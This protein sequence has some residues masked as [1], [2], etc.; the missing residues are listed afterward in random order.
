[1]GNLTQVT[2]TAS[3]KLPNQ[4]VVSLQVKREIEDEA[5]RLSRIEERVVT[6]GDVVARGLELL[7]YNAVPVP[8]ITP[9]TEQ[10]GHSAPINSELSDILYKFDS[11]LSNMERECLLKALRILRSGTQLAKSLSENLDGFCLGL[12]AMDEL[13]ILRE[14]MRER[15]GNPDPRSGAAPAPAS[16]AAGTGRLA[17]DA[18]EL[19]R[20]VGNITKPR[21]RIQKKQ[22]RNRA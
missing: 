11:A 17:A 19:E 4:V 8:V 16:D 7:K 18:A 2:Q 20:R 15:P 5:K 22:G 12:D 1:M 9:K 21:K 13:K 14:A 10:D 6:Q 3:K